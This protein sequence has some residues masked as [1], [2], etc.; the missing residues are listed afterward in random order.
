M[1]QNLYGK[2]PD[3]KPKDK[4]PRKKTGKG[5]IL[6]GIV[7]LLLVIVG[8]G[9]Y[10]SDSQLITK[11][12]RK[13]KDVESVDELELP[14]SIENLINEE[15]EQ[16]EETSDPEKDTGWVQ[17]DGEWYYLDDDH[18]PLTDQWIDDIYYVDEN[19]KMLRDTVT[20]DGRRVDKNGEVISMT[21]QAY[22]AFYNEILKLEKKLGKTGVKSSDVNAQDADKYHDMTGIGLIKLIDFNRDGLD[23]MLLGY[24]DTKDDKYHFRVY[25]YKNEELVNY[26]DDLMGGNG[27][28]MIYSVST[29]SLNGGEEYV[30]VHDGISKHRIYGFDADGEFKKLKDIGLREIDGKTANDSEVARVTDAWISYGE[31]VYPMTVL[32]NYYDRIGE[33][34][35]TRKAMRLEANN[36]GKRNDVIERNPQDY[37]DKAK[38]YTPRDLVEAVYEF[39]SDA[40]M[41]Y[42]YDDFNGDGS[43]DMVVMTVSYDHFEAEEGKTSAPDYKEEGADAFFDNG[44][45]YHA[46]WWFTDGYETYKF[47]D[48]SAPVMTGL[49]LYR[50]ETDR[51][52]QMAATMYWRDTIMPDYQMG[53]VVN[54]GRTPYMIDAYGTTGR[55]TGTESTGIIFRFSKDEGEVK[56]FEEEGYNFSV[57]NKNRIEYENAEYSIGADGTT[58]ENVSYGSLRYDAEEDCWIER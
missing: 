11:Y 25:G 54:N 31:T 13:Q 5:K 39:T 38:E 49:R 45:N 20:P 15:T 7:V 30:V 16:P 29:E 6:A 41:D 10:L 4:N 55:T 9:F 26:V 14:A 21:G 57:P 51:G 47:Y 58:C 46:E 52:I 24:L 28:P 37:P 18:E 35:E 42:I 23:E 34:Y 8:A 40:I 22:G 27:N 56:L 2:N 1:Q 12:L 50:V 33:I 3:R 36:S 32:M 48:F 44:Y 43:K 19:G 17:R 53:S